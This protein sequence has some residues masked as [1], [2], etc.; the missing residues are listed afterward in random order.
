MQIENSVVAVTGAA[1]GIGRALAA[2]FS[3]AGARLVLGDVDTAGLD[4][5]ADGITAAGGDVR[6]L[7]ADAGSITDLEALLATAEREFGPVDVFV[8]NA[9]IIG[10]PGLGTEADWDRIL[11]VNL[12]AHVRAATLLVPQWQERGRGHFVG[13]A[14]AAGLLTQIGAAGYAVT[15]HAAV[16]FA[17]WLAVTYGDDGIG[18][19]CVCPMGVDTPLL[20]AIRESP[21]PTA[22][23]AADSVV[24]AGAVITPRQVADL[25][26]AAVADGRF[27][28][29][30]HP[31][32]RDM[33]LGKIA[34]HDRWIEGMRRYQQSLRG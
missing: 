23:L 4:Q 29:L 15:K 3:A 10:G 28:V 6:T 13:V 26:V 24:S 33:A 11:D 17:E 22:H 21:D 25:T 5:T 32:V 7:R 8:A 31:E 1:S 18:V 9:G 16:G 34:D 2:A 20:T 19:T 30:P 27:L 14:S 12:R